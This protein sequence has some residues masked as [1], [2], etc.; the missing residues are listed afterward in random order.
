[1]LDLPG[2]GGFHEPGERDPGAV[3][4]DLAE[5]LISPEAAGAAYP[6]PDGPRHGA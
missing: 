6:T 4:R 3:A 5:G 1:V 2:G